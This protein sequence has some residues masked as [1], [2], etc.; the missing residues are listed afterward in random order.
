MDFRYTVQ[1][2]S[3]KR[4]ISQATAESIAVL[5]GQLK[6]QG[7]LPIQINEVKSAKTNVQKKS[8]SFRRK[9]KSVDLVTFTRQLSS[10]IN[11]GLLLTVALETICDDLENQYLH[12]ILEDL[13]R[14]IRAG[15]SFSKALMK[16]PK[17]FPSSFVAV[18]KAGE[19]G[20]ALGMTLT[21]L[22]K[23][24][25]DAERLNQKIKSASYYP[26]FI[27]TFFVFIVSGIIFFIIP[28]FRLIYAQLNAKL[29]PFT[30]F[31]VGLG[32]VALKNFYWIILAIIFSVVL[33]TFL[34]RLPKFKLFFDRFKLRL[35][36]FGKLIK[37]A[38]ISRLCRTLSILLSGGVG[39]VT[40]L[41]ISCEVANNVYLQQIVEDIKERV[42]A[43]SSLSAAFRNHNFFP[44]MLVKMI[45]VGEKTGKINDMLMRS[46]DYY[47]Q[48][49]EATVNA[50]TSIIEP[51]LIVLIGS[52]VGIVAVA[53]YLPIFK[54]A[55]LVK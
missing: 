13:I 54:I 33:F 19:E 1:D 5:V 21:N 25:E 10:S 53:F 6:S 41:P 26:V 9:V 35:W 14:D 32:E 46:A 8:Y 18:A 23:Y 3:G 28:K 51:T 31:I 55:S 36:I 27:F 29:P 47:D 15:S 20:G 48:E 50:L 45:Q 49:L 39:V 34:L 42:I 17:V 37:K 16:Y 44:R 24:L 43:G 11:S 4:I 7:L 2:K 38:A 52:I 30:S 12:N 22:A 40:A